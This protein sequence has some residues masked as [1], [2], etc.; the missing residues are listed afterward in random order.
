MKKVKT[1]AGY[2]QLIGS[3]IGLWKNLWKSYLVFP[4]GIYTYLHLK[5][6]TGD[7]RLGDERFSFV[8]CKINYGYLQTSN[9]GEAECLSVAACQ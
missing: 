6:E 9:L 7:W 5:M 4:Q 8:N 3:T 2:V 1:M